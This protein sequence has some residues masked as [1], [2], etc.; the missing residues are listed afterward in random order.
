MELGVPLPANAVSSHV[1]VQAFLD[2]HSATYGN[3]PP[4]EKQL[5]Y[6]EKLAAEKGVT[7]TDE[8]RGARAALGAFLDLHAPKKPKASPAKKTTTK[9]AR[10]P[11]A[12]A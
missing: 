2:A 3:L 8:Q 9:A 10:K 12:K 1:A 6:A 7:L 11:K 5:A 4:S